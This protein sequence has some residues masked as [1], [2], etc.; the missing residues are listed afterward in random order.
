[1]TKSEIA[2]NIR[3]I[4][5]GGGMTSDDMMLS[6]NQINF[7]IDYYRARLIKEYF[8]KYNQVNDYYIQD[9]GCVPIVCA[10]HAECCEVPY[11]GYTIKKL[12]KPLP[13]FIDLRSSNGITFLGLTDKIT[14]IPIVSALSS[15]YRKYHKYAK[16]NR[17]A[18]QIGNQLYFVLE[19][20]DTFEYV[21]IQGLLASP[22]S[23]KDYTNCVSNTVCY[24]D[25]QDYP[26]PPDLVQVLTEM[27]L[28]TELQIAI[29]TS[30]LSDESND[31][32]ATRQ[33]PSNVKS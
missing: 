33:Q 6:I 19:P 23:A 1:M 31:A 22:D 2:Y 18:Y 7:W 17:Y 25:E 20:G 4:A 26:I 24:S 16:F 12:K 14:A 30:G 11:S 5:V 3:N 8:Q 15:K 13:L 28:K 32:H 27:I 21:N 9:L 10:D 29:N